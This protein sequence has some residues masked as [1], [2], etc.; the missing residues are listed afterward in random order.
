MEGRANL[1]IKVELEKMQELKLAAMGMYCLQ[2]IL[3][4][5]PVDDKLNAN[6]PSHCKGK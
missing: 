4:D 3:H 5:G 6:S 1:E 2:P